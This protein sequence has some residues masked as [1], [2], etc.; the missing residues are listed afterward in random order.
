[1]TIVHVLPYGIIDVQYL[2]KGHYYRPYCRFALLSLMFYQREF[3]VCYEH[4]K[5]TAFYQYITMVLL[6]LTVFVPFSYAGEVNNTCTISLIT[7]PQGNQ[8]FEM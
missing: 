7:V 2:I 8:G 1:M 4:L 3:L 5:H 6:I